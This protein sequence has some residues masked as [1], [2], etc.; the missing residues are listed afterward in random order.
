M[1]PDF[2]A[3]R[4]DGIT[5]DETCLGDQAAVFGFSFRDLARSCVQS[6]TRVGR[7]SVASRRA[8]LPKGIVAFEA[9]SD[10]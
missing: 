1:A 6:V 5:E 3:S 8:A 10:S 7:R 4:G 9:A 2:A